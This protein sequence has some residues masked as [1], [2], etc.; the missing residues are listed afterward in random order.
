M[1]E[2]PELVS[3]T[4]LG[5]FL[6]Q[7][8]QEGYDIFLVTGDLPPCDADLVLQ[9]VPAVQAEPP[10]LLSDVATSGAGAGQAGRTRARPAGRDEEADL[11]AAMMLSLA[12][13]SGPDGAPAN[14]DSDQ[15]ARVM[16][17]QRQGNWETNTASEDEDYDDS[18]APPF[19]P[20]EFWG[21]VNKVLKG[22]EENLP[23]EDNTRVVRLATAMLIF[24]IVCIILLLV[25]LACR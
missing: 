8:Q 1:L 23:E 5:E 6:A 11:E 17:M 19:E 13:T 7:L 21:T 9:A 24:F 2:G 3:N 12:E 25:Y 22:A 20:M 4:Y 10:R 18:D 15:L 16:E 14:I